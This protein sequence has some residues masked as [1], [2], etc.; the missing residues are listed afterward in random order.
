MALKGATPAGIFQSFEYSSVGGWVVT[1]GAGQNST[2][3]GKI[4]DIVL[5]Q[6][7]VTPIGTIKTRAIPGRL[8]AL[9]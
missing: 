5:A 2:Y 7:Y 3:Y 6:E 8:P 4:E 9:T 1:R